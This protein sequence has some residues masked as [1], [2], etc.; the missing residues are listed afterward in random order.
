[1]PDLTYRERIVL[2][3]L[4]A[5]DGPNGSFPSISRLAADLGMSRT[6]VNQ[7]I[8]ALQEKARLKRIRRQRRTAV[9]EIAYGEPG[10]FRSAGNLDIK[11][12]LKCRKRIFR[13]AGNLHTIRKEGSGDSENPRLNGCKQGDQC[14][15]VVNPETDR[16]MTRGFEPEVFP[17]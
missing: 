3:E 15:F 14:G 11:E 9:N 2:A 6:A 5:Y 7:S 16:C 13:S 8:A 1:M 10:D 12:S 4:A 17:F